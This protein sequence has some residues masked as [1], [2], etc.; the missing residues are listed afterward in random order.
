MEIFDQNEEMKN[1]IKINMPE[2]A[3]KIL[4][5][6]HSAGFEAYVVGGCVRDS[7]LGRAPEDWDI[8]TSAKP[9]QI[10]ALFKRTIDTGIE[11]GTVT[12]MLGKEGFEITTYRIDGSYEDNRHPSDVSFTSS[13]E[14]D[15][16]RRDFTINAMCYNEETGLVD[17]YGGM[18]DIRERTIRCVGDPVKRFG[19]DALRIMRAVRFSAQLD[20]S[21]EE[22]TRKAIVTLA[23]TLKK[24]SAERIQTELSKLIVSKHPEKMMDCYKMGITNIILPELDKC[25][26][27][28]QNHPHHMYNVGEHIIV[29]VSNIRA[30]KILR[31]TMLF[32]DIAKPESLFIDEAGIHHFHGHPAKGAEM[33]EKIMKRLKFDKI[34][35]NRVCNLVRHHDILMGEDITAYSVRKAVYE[36]GEEDFPLIFEIKDADIMAQSLYQRDEKLGAVNKMREIYREVV[37][38]GDCL[39]LKSLAVHGR[40]LIEVGVKPGKEIGSIL[41]AMLMDVLKYPEHNNADYLLGD[42][43][44][45]RFAVKEG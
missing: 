13:L 31:Y 44:F 12:V 7:I 17:M 33:A 11:H 40:D 42:A 15:L 41:N 1:H 45:G 21:I 8:T 6:I 14:E 34:T 28:M 25:M 2:N 10:K 24:I 27:T 3:R 32:H 36:I 9:Q 39:S 37:D 38:K 23:P 22:A 43:N 26:D 35:M 30:D 4:S 19:E 20:Y 18:H 16:Q 5:V 29:S